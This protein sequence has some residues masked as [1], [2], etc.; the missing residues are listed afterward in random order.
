AER[1]RQVLEADPQVSDAFVA[2]VEHHEWG[3]QV[4]AAVVLSAGLD[5]EALRR[6][7][8]EALGPAA[9]PKQFH[10]LEALPRLANGKPDRQELLRLV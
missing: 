9:A 1:I 10:E 8:R 5:A 2:G 4:V 3:Q 6:R 7:V